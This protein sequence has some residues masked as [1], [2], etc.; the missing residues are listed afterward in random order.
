[1]IDKNSNPEQLTKKRRAIQKISLLP[2]IP[3]TLQKIIETSG[4]PNSSAGDLQNVIE[5]DQAISAAILKLSN[6]AYYGYSRQV[7]DIKRAIVIIG[8]NTAVSV[9]ISVSVLKSLSET[10]DSSEFDK[11]QFWKHTIAAGEAARSIAR[12]IKYQNHAEAYIIGLLHDIGKIVLY[13]IEDRDFEDAV[14]ESR[15]INKPLFE[16][17]MQIFGFDHQEAGGW[18]GDKWKLPESIVAGIQYHHD[19]AACPVEY[20]PGAELAFISNYV[21]KKT[22]I[23]NSGDMII[24]KLEPEI[25]TSMKITKETLGK[26]SASL[27]LKRPEIDL[28]LDTLL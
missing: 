13:F 1:M 18:L 15:A 25:L 26:I 16:C 9:A 24:P 17:E 5:K 23:G 10:L 19:F 22:G 7:E 27:E 21:V 20:R 3:T 6:S 28:F 2:S 8:F 12:E 14:F 4:D 11:D